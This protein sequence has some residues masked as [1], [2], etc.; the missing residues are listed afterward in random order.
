MFN[1]NKRQYDNSINNSNN[2]S[3]K[4]NK[5]NESEL[6]DKTLDNLNS[7]DK[8]LDESLNNLKIQD[9]SIYT[10]YLDKIVMLL[11]NINS[12]IEKCEKNI[13]NILEIQNNN[14]IEKNKKKKYEEDLLRSYTS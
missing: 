14:I 5:F 12:R 3:I 10:N 13:S 9:N 7:L 2:Y 6:L 11:E 4:K 8:S 1:Q